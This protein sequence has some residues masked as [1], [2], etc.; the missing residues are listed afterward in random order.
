[1]CRTDDVGAEL[2]QEGGKIERYDGFVL[3]EEDPATGEG[4]HSLC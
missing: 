1:M 3:D 2:R 4:V